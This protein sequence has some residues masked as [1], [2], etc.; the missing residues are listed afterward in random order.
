VTTGGAA[1]AAVALG[2]TG[3]GRGAAGELSRGVV[4]TGATGSRAGAAD[5][6]VSVVPRRADAPR[7]AG[8]GFTIS[9]RRRARTRGA[10]V[11]CSMVT[12]GPAQSGKAAPAPE[13][14]RSGVTKKGPLALAS[15]AGTPHIPPAPLSTR[16]PGNGRTLAT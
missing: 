11:S 12:A 5:A 6:L 15:P 2:V 8:R 9:G 16:P 3:A 13:A 10:A 7:A 1:T 4:A 14:P